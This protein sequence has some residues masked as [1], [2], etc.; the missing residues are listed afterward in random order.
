MTEQNSDQIARKRGRRTLLAI[1]L[2]SV[3]PIAAAYFMF[4]TGLGVP[5]HTVNHGVLLDQALP[6]QPMLSTEVWQKISADKKWRLLL[7]MG[8][9]CGDRC[10][11]QL[12]TTRQVHIRLGEK[13]AR[14][15]RYALNYG[16]D[17]GRAYLDSVASEHPLLKR[18]DTDAALWQQWLAHSDV[19]EDMS[20]E[21]FYLLVDQEGL[22]MMVY[23]DQH[24][25]ELLKDI[26]RALK[27]SID[28]TD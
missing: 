28:F 27:Y 25:N 7:P 21:P 8:E 6:L 16:G 2:I 22:A 20:A 4:F 23:T 19:L 11:Q 26:K 24:G 3:A 15:E 13:S 5:S 9:Q 17:K 1:L 18:V 10:A 14:V 12:Y